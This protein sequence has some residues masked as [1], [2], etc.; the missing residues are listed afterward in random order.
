MSATGPTKPR[1]S[2]GFSM[3][4]PFTTQKQVLQYAGN[5]ALRLANLGLSASP[6]KQTRVQEFAGA[7][8]DAA[9]TAQR[10]ARSRGVDSRLA[11]P[12][13]C[14]AAVTAKASTTSAKT[15]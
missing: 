6:T 5:C 7:A 4:I 11:V 1:S 2:A 3:A 10:A 12:R 14:G 8:S 13:G 9:L 15:C